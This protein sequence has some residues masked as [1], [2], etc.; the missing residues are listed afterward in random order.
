MRINR[1]HLVKYGH[2]DG[3]V[4][5][6][7]END[8]DMHII[9]GDNETGKSTTLAA[10]ENLL[11][12]FPRSTPY[13]FRFASP[14]LR[15]G[16]VL[17]SADTSF[18]FLRRKGNK[19]TI[20]D[21]DGKAIDGGEKQLATLLQGVDDEF[22]KRMFFLNH[23][24]LRAGSEDL[25]AVGED[26]GET[27]LA[28]GAGIQGLTDIL[29]GYEDD[30]DSLWA[31][32]SSQRRAFTQANNRL[33]AAKSAERAAS[34]NVN[35]YKRKKKALEK[36]S[37]A[38]DNASEDVQKLRARLGRLERI[39][40]VHRN[41]L[42]LIEAE[43][44]IA[45]LGAVIV[46]PENAH[47]Q[48]DD[49]ERDLQRR[50]SRSDVYEAQ[51]RKRQDGIEELSVDESML[52]RRA[53]IEKLS[54]TRVKVQ[55]GRDDLPRRREDLSAAEEAI[56]G[57][58]R[59][60]GWTPGK[61]QTERDLLPAAPTVSGARSHAAKFG[62]A[63]TTLKAAAKGLDDAKRA[64]ERLQNRAPTGNHTGD[65]AA[66][67]AA[68]SAAQEG[69]GV[70]AAREAAEQQRERAVASVRTLLDGLK[71]AV[72]DVDA[73]RAMAV[74]GVTVIESHRDAALSIKHKRDALEDELKKARRVL[75]KDQEG[76]TRRRESGLVLT[77]ADLQALRGQRDKA[78]QL[79]AAKHVAGDSVSEA[80]WQAIFGD[81]ASG[82]SVYEE[83]VVKADSGADDRFTHAEAAARLNELEERIGSGEQQVAA[84]ESDLADLKKRLGAL[85]DEWAAMWAEA[86]LTPESPDRMLTWSRD[87]EE[88][89]LKQTEIDAATVDIEHKRTQESGL[90][91]AL[92]ADMSALGTDVEQL[93][94]RSLA[95]VLS[96]AT[97]V[98]RELTAAR[99]AAEQHEETVREAADMQVSRQKVFDTARS[100]LDDWQ[101]RWI[102]ILAEL[103][104]DASTAH[105]EVEGY[106]TLIESVRQNLDKADDI[107]LNR[108]EK[109]E[110]N[111]RS[112][113]ERTSKLV[114]VIADDLSGMPVDDAVVALTA[115]LKEAEAN[116]ARRVETEADIEADKAE[117][118]K[119][120]AEE[121][122][123]KEVIA[124]LHRQASTE[125][126]DDLKTA[127]GRSAELG[128]LNAQ[129][130]TIA[131]TLDADG[132]DRSISELKQEVDGV[133][134]DVAT[135]EAQTLDEEVKALSEAVLPLHEAMLEAKAEFEA[136]GTS[137]E[138]A[139]AASLIQSAYADMDTIAT[140]FV[141]ARTAE[142]L[143]RW[144]ID[145]FRKQKQGP[146][147]D[148]AST[149]FNSVTG[150]RYQ[151]LVVEYDH[152]T[153]IL[154]GV[155]EDASVKATHAMSEGTRD[156][157]YLALR[158]AA[159][160]DYIERST[161]MPFV[162]DDIFVNF[163]ETRTAYA[164]RALQELANHCQ[165]VVFTHHSHVVEIAKTV[166]GDQASA[167][168]LP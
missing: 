153:P 161:P 24:R 30:A 93:A 50:S 7:P 139:V 158:L 65:P 1:L 31:R 73:L 69:S 114:A 147:L 123:S 98:D 67:R 81:D 80:E 76:A 133:D 92:V 127:I 142:R 66:L 59:D 150:G 33:K 79:L 52:Q 101:E 138:A 54:N 151:R 97:G 51:I 115:R 86:G 134:L 27:L 121:R 49:A 164:M 148:K 91:D 88:C 62:T 106:L 167:V 11:F 156:Q 94:D 96:Y 63:S 140:S 58:I 99:E 103:G 46:L 126:I 144:G 128:R 5:D 12:G 6:L 145:Y 149:L 89:L 56:A 136:I 26:A 48:L 20:V 109:I 132:D 82:R 22:F 78:W 116:L 112:F 16:A 165:V 152:D 83:L 104:L 4:I 8:V 21:E 157:L 29:Q 87:R 85:N 34:V 28:S 131:T 125:T 13:D 72:P 3:T 84:H 75:E 40:R 141:R 130:E 64:L 61:D 53:D 18:E 9:Y 71:P 37:G 168:T 95:H 155:D 120:A 55:D 43:E 122:K 68:I 117:L 135:A 14:Q 23:R 90:I 129:L 25:L 105:D 60:L 111:I 39:R 163:D 36:A 74:P 119:L 15:I 45:K 107:R 35:E 143:L 70:V 110:R 57:Q 118:R 32:T 160:E 108:I 47:A 77:D 154:A 41:V 44:A 113:E 137:G 2:F 166:A 124:E 19:D 162:A 159:V 42:L 146:L 102:E 100:E 38:Y 10:L 17:Q